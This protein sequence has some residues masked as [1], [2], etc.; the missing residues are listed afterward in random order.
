MLPSRSRAL[1]SEAGVSSS[2]GA[3][4]WGCALGA[5]QAEG[6]TELASLVPVSAR[7][8][9]CPVT[10]GVLEHPELQKLKLKSNLCRSCRAPLTRQNV[11][12]P[13]LCRQAT[14]AGAS[15]GAPAP[16]QGRVDPEEALPCTGVL[17]PSRLGRGR[18]KQSCGGCPRDAIREANS[19]S[20]VPREPSRGLGPWI[21][22]EWPWSPTI[23]GAPSLPEGNWSQAAT[24]PSRGWGGP[25]AARA[26][27]RDSAG[28][29]LP[30]S[31]PV[32]TL[33]PPSARSGL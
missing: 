17:W 24:G 4:L 29:S 22:A 27:A 13:G 5:L 19:D 20:P 15:E 32:P 7:L 9:S 6:P 1:R 23:A 10:S 18:C 26:G 8:C 30:P 16:A 2:A 3:S 33:L 14:V 21:P 28:L 25:R 12:A 11:A 31:P